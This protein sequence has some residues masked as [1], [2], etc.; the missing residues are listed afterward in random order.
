[1]T[2]GCVR[3]QVGEE[4][5]WALIDTGASVSFISSEFLV[6]IRDQGVVVT[7]V[8]ITDSVALADNTVYQI[9]SKVSMLITVHNQALTQSFYVLPQLNRS[10]IL[11]LNFMLF[12][13]A[14]LSFDYPSQEEI[15]IPVAANK[16]FTVPPQS[17][18]STMAHVMTWGNVKGSAALTQAHSE[19]AGLRAREALV[20][21]HGAKGGHQVVPITVV[22]SGLDPIRVTRG[23]RVATLV[24]LTRE[25]HV[26]Q[27]LGGIISYGNQQECSSVPI[28]G[29]EDIISGAPS[30]GDPLQCILSDTL[31]DE[32][33][34]QMRIVIENN[35]KAFVTTDSVTGRGSDFKI[36]IKLKEGAVPSSKSPYRTTPQKQK[37]MDELLDRH[38]AQGVIM[39]SAE[40][41]EWNA[42]IFLVKKMGV[43]KEGADQYRIVLDYRGLNKQLVD[44]TYA[45]PRADDVV[46]QIGQSKSKYFTRLDI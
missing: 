6:N 44:Y 35:R 40:P 16:H 26:G 24:M 20:V 3:V 10:M 18:F 9:N 37:Y 2:D 23:E 31:T 21:P 42:P 15:S 1:M 5:I 36:A 46:E 38:V 25:S 11:G 17:E 22:N 33:K 12:Q 14:R 28:N 4:I 45:F 41:L 13:R 34:T 8:N 30:P 39:E 27:R 43:E 19:G 32:Q 7:E 29:G